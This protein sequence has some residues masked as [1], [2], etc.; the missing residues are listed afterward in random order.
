MKIWNVINFRN[1]KLIYWLIIAIA[2][3]SGMGTLVSRLQIESSNRT[4]ELIMSYNT[5][6]MMAKSYGM[7]LGTML[8][9]VASAGI[10]SIAIEE[11]TLETLAQEGRISWL[12]SDVLSNTSRYLK[13]A[14]PVMNYIL[15][16]GKLQPE[17]NYIIFDDSAIMNV[18]KDNLILQLGP[19]RVRPMNMNVLQVKGAFEPLK[20][21]PLGFAPDAIERLR[22]VNA[23]FIA[24]LRQSFFL[25]D[26]KIA[27]KI[28]NLATLPIPIDKV[29]FEGETLL[30]YKTHLPA[31]ATAF[32]HNNIIFGFVEF[33]F[34]KGEDALAARIPEQTMK[35]HSIPTEELSN[36]NVPQAIKRY[37]RA[38]TERKIRLLVVNPFTNMEINSD[39][40]ELNLSYITALSDRLHKAGYKTG[41][42]AQLNFDALNPMGPVQLVLVILALCS[43][44]MLILD[45]FV[46][47]GRLPQYTGLAGALIFSIAATFLSGR[48]PFS[49]YLA[50]AA[51]VLF[52]VYAVF[53]QFPGSKYDPP[54]SIRHVLKNTLLLW[55][56]SMAGAALVII[57]L[58][59]PEYMVGVKNF[60]G[61]KLAFLGP[62]LLVSGYYFVGPNRLGSFLHVVK[63]T[64]SRTL[65]VG[66]VVGFAVLA[67]LLLFYIVRSGNNTI[68]PVSPHE[69]RFR[70]VLETLLYARPRT[71]EILL[72][73]PVL[74][75]SLYGVNRLFK[76]KRL[77]IGATIAT[78]A[79]ISIIN[80]FAHIHSPLL[81]SL[82]RSF[83][84]IVVGCIIGVLV[85]YAYRFFDRLA[86][87]YLD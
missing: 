1:P 25:D 73:Y 83:N 32:R 66:Y 38:V 7:P 6:A 42:A 36:Y 24:R 23:N 2:I 70:E 56:I 59:R 43:I 85:I 79:P 22:S 81:I 15:A 63:R 44:F 64:F 54:L 75:F 84:G 69:A 12:T 58:S 60:P 5:L 40:R 35:V 77:W 74:M 71:K 45:R 11:M 87:R 21:L 52:P 53:S 50:L 19:D 16:S 55:L 30:G 37:I 41:R 46:Q 68:V 82:L 48:I 80:T 10:N 31:V 20:V 29:V 33:A 65:T 39:L 34:Q 26:E 4:V 51:A 57:V 86:A 8:E 62:L 72:A 67:L 9:Q 49:P 27:A 76:F 78:M 14:S 18:V 61:V 13:N 47:F 28:A 17:D 3:L